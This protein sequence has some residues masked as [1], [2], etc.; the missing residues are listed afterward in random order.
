L[1]L[2]E[3][4]ISLA[5]TVVLMTATFNALMMMD[6]NSR[7]VSEFNSALAIAEA[8][9][10]QTKTNLYNPPASPFPASVSL[11]TNT[12]S[13]AL[14]SVGTNFLVSGRVLRRIEPVTGGHLVTVVASFTNMG[15]AYRAEVQAVVNRYT[16]GQP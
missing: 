11:T 1:T 12:V 8:V 14:D 3:V 10:E 16:G 15:L 2:I 5:L 7:R 6:R 4:S 13:V 9:L